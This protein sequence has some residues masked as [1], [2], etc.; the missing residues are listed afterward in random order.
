MRSRPALRVA[1]LATASVL[2]LAGCSSTA[3][4]AQPG[5]T[6]SS[7]TTTAGSTTMSPTLDPAAL[8]SAYGVAVPPGVLLTAPGSELKVLQSATIAWAPKA[9]LVGALTI[10]VT[11]LRQGQI[12]D[13][14]GFTI[15]DR[16]RASTPYYVDAIVKNVGTSNLSGV[17][18]PLYLLDQTNTLYESSG[19]GGTFRPCAA[20][21]LP[22]G[23]TAGKT[24]RVCLVY[25]APNHGTL[26]AITFRPTQAF[27]PITWT[28]TVIKPA[29][30]P[31]K[32]SRKS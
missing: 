17:Q 26:E 7:G 18:V 24:V 10:T 27:N 12:K 15:D 21:P 23:F 16:T 8:A 19:F 1:A 14:D 31:T 2:A 11:R 22:A 25:L 28:G 32:K 13:F 20:Q 3:N 30:K 5:P 9:K 6:S 29:R 4:N